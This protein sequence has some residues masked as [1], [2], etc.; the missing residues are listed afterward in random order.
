MITTVSAPSTA[1]SAQAWWWRHPEVPAVGAITASWLALGVGH[2]ADHTH[3]L[4][5]AW[6]FDVASWTAMVVA[7]MLPGS[8]PMLR[9]VAFNS[10]WRRRHRSSSLF[11][12][13]YVASWTAIGVAG[14]A[15]VRAA[16]T[17]SGGTFSPAPW[18][19]S[20]LLL[21]AAAWQFTAAK[22]RCLR[23][24]HL[25][26]AL[27]PR[28]WKADRSIIEYGVFHSR[29]CIGSC[30]PVMAAMFVSGH[31]FHLM[32]PL[33][34]VTIAERFQRRPNATATGAALVA[35]AALSLAV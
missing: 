3:D 24:C 22:Q 32:V 15:T 8:V 20:A 26:T 2:F 16:E 35:L 12:L 17:V 11:A 29:A 5:S 33:A 18:L 4:A 13:T 31:S 21:V 10:I 19:V 34:A 27:K 28:G 1:T 9:R 7:M 25:R 30:A 14:F 23:A 6:H